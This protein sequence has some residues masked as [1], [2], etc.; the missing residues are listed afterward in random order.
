MLR[1]ADRVRAEIVMPGS[2]PAVVLQ[3][4]TR[5]CTFVGIALFSVLRPRVRVDMAN[6][7][8]IIVPNLW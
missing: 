5:T 6:T 3:R 4:A 7:R 2:P 1:L 8:V